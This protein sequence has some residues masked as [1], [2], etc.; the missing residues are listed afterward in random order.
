MESQ[1]C[2]CSRKY[3]HVV[4]YAFGENNQ[5]NLN[6]SFRFG[7]KKTVQDTYSIVP[8]H[9]IWTCTFTWKHTEWKLILSTFMTIVL[10]HSRGA[11]ESNLNAPV[12]NS[13]NRYDLIF[14]VYSPTLACSHLQSFKVNVDK[15]RKK[16]IPTYLWKPWLKALLLG[17]RRWCQTRMLGVEQVTCIH[18][19]C[20]NLSCSTSGRGIQLISVSKHFSAKQVFSKI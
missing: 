8:Q 1:Y 7:Y 5:E 14:A 13:N 3:F 20:W 10:N 18:I 6:Q 16:K 4:L 19:K 15:E 9:L 17:Q 12:W 11:V 2:T